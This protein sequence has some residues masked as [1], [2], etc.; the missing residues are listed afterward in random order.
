MKKIF[1]IAL[2]LCLMISVLC[3]TTFT[4]SAEEPG[5]TQEPT[6]DTVLRLSALKTNGD[7]EFIKDYTS[8]EKGWNAA[9]DLATNGSDMKSKNYNRVVVDLYAD[10]NADAN[11]VFG[12]NDGKGFEEDTIYIPNDCRVTINMNGHTIN[13]GLSDWKY[14]GEVIYIYEDTDV[15]ING[16]KSGDPIIM[17]GQDPGDVKLGTIKGG[18]SCNGAGGIHINEANV[19]LNN[20]NLVNNKV[21]DDDG[22]AIAIHYGGNLTMNGGCL[23]NNELT[24]FAPTSWAGCW[25]TL[26][27]DDSTATLNNVVISG[28]TCSVLAQNGVAVAMTGDSEITLNNCIVENNGEATGTRYSETILYSKDN[29]GVLNINGGEIRNNYAKDGVL[30]IDGVLNVNGTKITKNNSKKA[31]I[32]V[33]N[34]VALYATFENVTITD[35]VGPVNIFIDELRFND[36]SELHFTNCTINNNTNTDA[37]YSIRGGEYSIVTFTDCDLGD[38]TYRSK[39]TI[40][41]T[42]TSAPDGAHTASIFTEGSLAMIVAILSLVA[43]TV[44]ICLTVVY[45]KRLVPVVANDAP[46]SEESEENEE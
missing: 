45:K 39:E 15:I 4:T 42:D 6:P 40:K 37:D 38:S 8:F 21:E 27:A 26:Y 22:A 46:E 16:G 10:W 3:I 17:P 2:T 19:T 31:T 18:F 29:G 30:Y 34:S 33:N 12:D 7:I 35:N 13:R 41:F 32:Y 1:V 23:S 20:V 14:D 24:A 5:A 9:M 44:S 11:G 43:S 36:A 28:N 25:G